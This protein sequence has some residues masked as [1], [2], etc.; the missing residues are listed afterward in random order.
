MTHT[1]DAN[2]RTKRTPRLNR[3]MI[4][5]FSGTAIP[6]GWVLCD[7]SNGT[8]DL[9][10]RF[11]IGDS[12]AGTGTAGGTV[13]AT[14]ALTHAGMAVG[15]HSAHAVTQPGAHSSHSVG[16]AGAHPAHAVG[17]AGAHSAHASGGA[18]THDAHTTGITTAGAASVVQDNF[19][20]SSD[21]A[22][23]HDAHSAHTGADLDGHSAHAGG[24]LDAHSAHAGAALDAHSAH[25]VTQP[26]SHTIVKHVLLVYVMWTGL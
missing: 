6:D 26:D 21:G 17:Q 8:P 12:A 4:V 10:D 15:A 14:A 5:A 20:H 23:A 22:H 11:L 9:R 3:G 1:I 16:Q 25:S 24:A 13:S 2:G 7:G 19:T 18:H